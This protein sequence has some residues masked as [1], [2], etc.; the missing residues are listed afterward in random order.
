[1]IKLI[2]LRNKDWLLKILPIKLKLLAKYVVPRYVIKGY[3]HF[4]TITSKNLLS[5]AQVKNIIFVEKLSSVSNMFES[6][7][8][9]HSVIY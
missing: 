8:F 1:M 3:D 4:K 2:P 9:K 6:C 5:E 7:I